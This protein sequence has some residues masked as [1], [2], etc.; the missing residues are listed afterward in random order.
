MEL[1]NFGFSEDK[2][3]F[4]GF[5]VASR[6]HMTTFWPISYEWKSNDL[7][8]RAMNG[9]GHIGEWSVLTSTLLPSHWKETGYDSESSLIM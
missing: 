7:S 5:L 2:L 1:A 6:R 3:Q 9:R 4:P 8:R